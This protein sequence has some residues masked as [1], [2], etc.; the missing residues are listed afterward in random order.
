MS[1]LTEINEM[2]EK[3]PQELLENELTKEALGYVERSAYTKGQLDAYYDWKIDIMTEIAFYDDAYEKGVKKGIED[4]MEKGME[5][6]IAQEKAKLNKRI[7]VNSFQEGL[8]L[9]II[10]TI[11]NL[12]VEKVT[13]ILK[14]EKLL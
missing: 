1:F 4:G 2:T 8:S 14:Q 3:A 11:T 7:V 13:G 10:S 5:K 9:D 12:S 6:G